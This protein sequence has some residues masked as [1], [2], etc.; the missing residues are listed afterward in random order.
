MSNNSVTTGSVGSLGSVSV[1]NTTFTGSNIVT[2]PTRTLVNRG[3]LNN[4]SKKSFQNEVRT[5]RN[6]YYETH[7]NG[8]YS[9][10]YPYPYNDTPIKAQ[11]SGAATNVVNLDSNKSSSLERNNPVTTKDVNLT[12]KNV[13]SNNNINPAI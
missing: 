5:V 11:L 13:S 8:P 9:K 2:K 10:A 12:S 6:D 4:F 7:P 1:S 3:T